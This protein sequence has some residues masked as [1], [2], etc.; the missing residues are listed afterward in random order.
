MLIYALRLIP[1]MALLVIMGKGNQVCITVLSFSTRSL[2]PSFLAILKAIAEKLIPG[3]PE[4]LRVLLVGQIED[5]SETSIAEGL[6][7]A[8]LGDNDAADSQPEN[9]TV[10]EMVLHSDDRRNTAVWEHTRMFIG[11]RR[12]NRRLNPFFTSS[13]IICP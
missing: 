1:L 12:K 6:S 9:P 13:S 4:N 2:I 3:I 8:H 7:K 5:S 10:V 11:C